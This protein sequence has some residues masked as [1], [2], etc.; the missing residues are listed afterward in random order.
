MTGHGWACVACLRWQ[1][2]TVR[3]PTH[4]G[5]IG[6]AQAEAVGGAGEQAAY[7]ALG[8]LSVVHLH[9]WALDVWLRLR[10]RLRA[11]CV[12]GLFAA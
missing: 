2:E 6:G 1:S 5:L 8:G 7:G 10:L 11:Q 9:W 3:H 4:P 12:G